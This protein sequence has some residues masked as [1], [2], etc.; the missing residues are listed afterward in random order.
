MFYLSVFLKYFLNDGQY[1]VGRKDC[2]ILITNDQSISRKHAVFT[3]KV[4]TL[5]KLNY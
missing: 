5:Y 2:D 4:S 3:V 1:T